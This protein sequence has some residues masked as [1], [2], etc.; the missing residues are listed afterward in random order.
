MKI[1]K[2]IW[3]GIIILFL[4]GVGIFSNY[5]FFQ[6][7]DTSSSFDLDTL[8]LKMSIKQGGSAVNNIQIT[9]TNSKIEHFLIKVNEIN[10]IVNLDKYE[11]D[12]SS[13]ESVDIR[14]VFNISD[15]NPGVYLGEIEVQSNRNS[16]IIPVIFEIESKEVLFDGNLNLFPQTANIVP[17]QKLNAEVKIFDL[18]DV[19]KSNVELVYS[20]KSFDG[21]NIIDQ[22]ESLVIDSQYVYSRS[23]D[24]PKNIRLGNYVLYAVLKYKNST[25][26]SSTFFKVVSETEASASVGG[27]DRI[28]IYIVI[29]FGFFF[30]IFLGLFVYSLFFR[31]K[32][33]KE[34]EKQYKRELRRERELIECQRKLMISKSRNPYEKKE[35]RK[36]LGKVKKQRI[37]ALKELRKH[38]IKEFKRI[39]KHYKGN[40]LQKQLNKWKKQGYDTQVLEK[41]YKFPS[42]NLI[43]KKI[44][45]WKKQ[46][47]DTS[48]LR[49]K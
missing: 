41:K 46:G 18:A 12:L 26:T 42:I 22:S 15:K 5:Y 36:E 27:S 1:K 47:Y 9:N 48:V 25:G 38:K 45:N 28:I 24:L 10:N 17:G 7:E 32:M 40:D 34:M 29:M 31:D 6:G 2:Y 44:N 33:L 37:K 4:I 19:G 21:R 49:K 39:K 35:F 20:I 3:I 16:K 30:L 23:I 14:V 8:F 13:D 11:F 43:R